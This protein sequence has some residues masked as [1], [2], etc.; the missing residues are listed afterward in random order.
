VA[1]GVLATAGGA[2]EYRR[3]VRGLPPAD[4][5]GSSSPPFILSLAWAIVVIGLVLGVVLVL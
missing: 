3:F 1:I 5:P 2:L 4:R